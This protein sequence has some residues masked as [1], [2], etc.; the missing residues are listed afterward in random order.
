MGHSP[1]V[2][3]AHY[4]ELVTRA[5][6]ERFFAVF[7]GALA[8]AGVCLLPPAP[9]RDARAGTR[10]RPLVTLDTFRR[11]FHHGARAGVPKRALALE[12]IAEGI[13]EST[14]HA[15]LAEGGHLGKWLVESEGRFSL[16]PEAAAPSPG[17]AGTAAA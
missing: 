2:L 17:T 8:V 3:F 5:Q 1:Q 14:A 15:S 11:L 4:R 13:S 7:P 12:L 10:G 6:A 9:P 16:A